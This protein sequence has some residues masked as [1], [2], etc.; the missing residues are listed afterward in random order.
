M[1]QSIFIG[2]AINSIID[3]FFIYCYKVRIYTC[4]TEYN[5]TIYSFKVI[6]LFLHFIYGK[7]IMH[8]I[9]IQYS[10]IFIIIVLNQ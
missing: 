8:K 9:E 5:S 1:D 4:T 3:D 7:N 6:N 10:E 2:R